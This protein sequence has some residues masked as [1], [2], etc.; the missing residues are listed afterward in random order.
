M[1]DSA[2]PYIA[3][4]VIVRKEGKIAFVLRNNTKWMNGFYGLPSGKIEK[5]E[6]FS[7]GAI[8][9]AKE[10]IGITIKP[11]DLKPIFIL[12]RGANVDSDLD[13][14]DA[15][16]EA[17]KWS[18]EP[19][20]AEPNVHSE[21]AWLDPNNLPKN[22]VPSVLFALQELAAGKNYSEYGWDQHKV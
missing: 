14:V 19:Y 6:S 3:S 10:E 11:N 8:R 15:Y 9:E 5:G 1:Y 17:V 4:F 16:F 22:V 7:A 21:L 20:N 2:Q 18:G 13:W 12:H